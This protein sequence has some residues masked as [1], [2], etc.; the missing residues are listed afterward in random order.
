LWAAVFV[1]LVV[2][3]ALIVCNTAVFALVDLRPAILMA[4]VVVA[5]LVV[6]LAAVLIFAFIAAF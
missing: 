5:A 6:S 3:A 2:V 1:A 4:F